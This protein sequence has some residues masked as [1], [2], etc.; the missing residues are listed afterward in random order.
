ML[1]LLFLLFSEC[2]LELN[3]TLLFFQCAHLSNV[4]FASPWINLNNRQKKDIVLFLARTQEPVVIT[5]SKL[6]HVSLE[7]FTK[8]TI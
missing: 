3:C 6:I 1:N 8:V 5:A 2:L 7:T 4:V